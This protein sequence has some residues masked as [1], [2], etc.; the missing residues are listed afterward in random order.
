MKLS[1]GMH[2]REKSFYL[3]DS[4]INYKKTVLHIFN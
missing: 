4:T 1:H 2:F 3:P